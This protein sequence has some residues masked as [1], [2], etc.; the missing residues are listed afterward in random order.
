MLLVACAVGGPLLG[1]F[2]DRIGSRKPIYMACCFAG[3][4]GWIVILFVPELPLWVLGLLMTVTGFSAGVMVL[5]FAF[6]KE[7]VPLSLA[8][9]VS[10][11]CNMG[12]MI[13]PMVLQPAMGYV[14]DSKW[15]GLLENGTRVY[16][17]DAY[18]SAFSLMIAW[19][20]ISAILTCF[21]TE[22]NCRQIVE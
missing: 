2:S 5:S 1:A 4:A 15:N 22:T 16:H 17:L 13:G 11:V 20:V 19:S 14:L 12:I 9:T 8:G 3:C 21:T 7:S 10:G 6:V 18:Q